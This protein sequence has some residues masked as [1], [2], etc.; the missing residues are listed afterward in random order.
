[1]KESNIPYQADDVQSEGFIVYDEKIKTPR[2]AI[3]VAHAWR[4]QDDFARDK[5]RELA[6]LGYIGFAADLFGN[7]K[8]A[9][10]DDDAGALN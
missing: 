2:P 5:A 3:I 4:G 6:K 9:T 7:R 1:M 8:T 10:N